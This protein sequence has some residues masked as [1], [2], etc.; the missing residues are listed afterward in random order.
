[1]VK[2]KSFEILGSIMDGIPY[3]SI[4]DVHNCTRQFVSAIKKQAENAGILKS[5]SAKPSSLQKSEPSNVSR[6]KVRL[7]HLRKQIARQE[8]KIRRY[9][10]QA[11][12][13]LDLEKS[14]DVAA[15]ANKYGV[16]KGRVLAWARIYGIHAPKTSCPLKTAM[17]IV[18]LLMQGKANVEIAKDP[19]ITIHQV[20]HTKRAAQLAGVLPTTSTVKPKR[21]KRKHLA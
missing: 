10:D 11:E 7:N 20:T 9:T 14:F 12:I 5:S 16:K 21:T 18:A 6:A 4:A 17:N 15:T 3:D 8:E 2:S 19:E 13:A 1:M